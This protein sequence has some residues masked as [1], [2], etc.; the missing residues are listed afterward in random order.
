M[1]TTR[2]KRRWAELSPSSR[3][4]ILVGA[5]IEGTLKVAALIDLARRP[6]DEIRGSKT[7]WVVAIVIVNSGGA[8]PVYYFAH[9]RRASATRD[10]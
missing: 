7:K 9:G 2:R 8:L 1:R 3:K 6:S 5:A 4:M 10:R